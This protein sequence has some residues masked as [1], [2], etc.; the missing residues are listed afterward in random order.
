MK[1]SKSIRTSLTKIIPL[2]IL[3]LFRKTKKILKR[4]RPRLKDFP[5]MVMLETTTRCNL[6]CNHCPNS[7]L[8]KDKKWVGD[9]GIELYKKL[10][11][12]ISNEDPT[13]VVRPF[14]SGEPLLR[15]DMEEMIEYAKKKGIQ[16][17]SINTN[18]VLL[19]E[20]RCQKLLN[21]G[22]DHIEISVDAMSKETFKKIKNVDLYDR[23]K[24]NILK[25]IQLRDVFRPDFIISVSFVKQRDNAHETDAFYA[26]WKEKV[27]RV[28]IRK[29]HR[30]ANLVE[31]FGLSEDIKT[32]ESRMNRR[33]PCPYLWDRIIVQH[34]GRVRFCENDWKAE[35]ALGNAWTQTLK[36]IWN[37]EAYQNLRAS[38]LKGTFSHP[39]CRECPDWPMI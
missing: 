1:K 28:Y 19:N 15:K 14:D 37:S 29:Y 17:V 16:Y 32:D 8:S 36:E 10:I 21:S 13:T 24:E 6:A 26:Y 22:L 12:E 4:N 33:H 34:D 31:D 20:A 5:P 27:N 2:S 30:H 35:F 25:L 18:G 9:M 23:V 39:F 11:D 3:T 38:H 7:I